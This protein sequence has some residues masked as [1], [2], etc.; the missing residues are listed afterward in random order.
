MDK[1]TVAPLEGFGGPRA[2]RRRSLTGR[3]R[4]GLG[5]TALATLL[6]LSACN[7]GQDAPATVT[8][9]V[10]DVASAHGDVGNMALDVVFIE[11]GG[12]VMAGESAP[13]RGNFINHAD[14]PDQLVSVSTPAAGSI[15][16]LGA[17]GV[18]SAHGIDVPPQG[19]VDAV[20]GVVRLQLVDA[21]FPLAATRLVPVTFEFSG[22]G[23]V[24][25]DVPVAVPPA[26]AP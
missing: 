13:L 23:E 16:L 17:D 26:P 20:N 9:G 19:Q 24:T 8:A 7:A 12:T 14:T 25:L 4:T 11:S 6:G 3:G 22:A 21:L 15:E 18:P 10:P 2:R 5:A 1:V